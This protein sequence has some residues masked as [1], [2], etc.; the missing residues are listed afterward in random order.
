[1][2]RTFDSRRRAASSASP[3]K[4][5]VHAEPGVLQ[6]EQRD[7][8]GAAV[9]RMSAGMPS[10]LP[11]PSA[12]KSGSQRPAKATPPVIANAVPFAT[13]AMASVAISDGICSRVTSTR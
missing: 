11:R 13:D 3:V 5:H 12:R 2:R 6:H 7:E 1:M 8:R 4:H 10:T 9:H